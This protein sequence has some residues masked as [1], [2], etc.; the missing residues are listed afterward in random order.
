MLELSVCK[1]STSF[2]YRVQTETYLIAKLIQ[3]KEN[4]LLSSEN[5]QRTI[6]IFMP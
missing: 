1:M 3:M 5:K 4:V 6:V 2:N